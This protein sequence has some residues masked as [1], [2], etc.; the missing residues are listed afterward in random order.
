[1]LHSTIVASEAAEETSTRATRHHQTQV[2]PRGSYSF[3]E[4]ELIPGSSVTIENK[5][6][7]RV[8]SVHQSAVAPGSLPGGALP[9]DTAVMPTGEMRGLGEP[10]GTVPAAFRHGVAVPRKSILGNKDVRR[11]GNSLVSMAPAMLAH[12]RNPILH[13]R[14]YLN[15]SGGTAVHPNYGIAPDDRLRQKLISATRPGQMVVRPAQVQREQPGQTTDVRAR[16]ESTGMAPSQ[17]GRVI[18][19]T[20][21]VGRAPIQG[22][23]EGSNVSSNLFIGGVALALAGGVWWLTIR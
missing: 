20:R 2:I 23:S 8:I 13:D 19:R 17:P 3:G 7:S 15:H 6:V 4:A 21:L 1:M 14:Q 11:V 22:L 16:Y 18:P 5:P 9:R 12:E 10:L